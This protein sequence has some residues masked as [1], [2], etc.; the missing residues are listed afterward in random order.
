MNLSRHTYEDIVRLLRKESLREDERTR[1][2]AELK[3]RDRAL[4]NQYL[5]MLGCLDSRKMHQA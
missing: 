2:L 3:S 4:E 5:E 1:M